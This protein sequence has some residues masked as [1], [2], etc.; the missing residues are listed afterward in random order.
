MAYIWHEAEAVDS[1]KSVEHF[2]PP[3]RKKCTEH[4]FFHLVR[5]DGQESI[6]D[7]YGLNIDPERAMEWAERIRDQVQAIDANWSD[8]SV[9][10]CDQYGDEINRIPV[11]GQKGGLQW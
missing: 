2:P 4:I 10:V 11:I 1:R 7:P 8:W 9:S 3:I 6:P 5:N